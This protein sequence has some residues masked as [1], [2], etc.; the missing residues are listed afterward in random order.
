MV[1]ATKTSEI[2]CLFYRIT[3][4]VWLI[5]RNAFQTDNTKNMCDHNEKLPTLYQMQTLQN[6]GWKGKS[7]LQ[8]QTKT[9]N[10]GE[11]LFIWMWICSI[12]QSFDKNEGKN[13]NTEKLAG[14]SIVIQTGYFTNTNLEY[15]VYVIL[16]PVL[17]ETT[18]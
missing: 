14:D 2:C 10:G 9:L 5:L 11:G 15:R 3:H 1:Q 16:N 4:V 6:L 12:I 17:N 13:K 8:I 7:G 18:Q